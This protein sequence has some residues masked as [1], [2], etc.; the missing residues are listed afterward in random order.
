MLIYLS[1]RSGNSL[2]VSDDCVDT[3]EYTCLFS[4]PNYAPS[5]SLMN[6]AE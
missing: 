4:Y 5:F 2:L 1:E 6:K 3:H